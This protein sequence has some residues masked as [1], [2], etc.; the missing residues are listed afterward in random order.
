MYCTLTYVKACLLLLSH[1]P[2]LSPSPPAV[3]ARVARGLPHDGHGHP[4]NR[5][6][7]V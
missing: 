7:G 3:H 2:P 1:Q 6:S 5:R 4:D